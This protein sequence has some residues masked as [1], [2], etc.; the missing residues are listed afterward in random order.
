[1]KA[2]LAMFRPR[3]L[4]SSRFPLPQYWGLIFLIEKFLDYEIVIVKMPVLGNVHMKPGEY[5]IIT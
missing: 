2:E 1:M 3:V 4:I 5:T